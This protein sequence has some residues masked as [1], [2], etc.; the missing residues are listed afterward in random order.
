MRIRELRNSPHFER[1]A[2]PGTVVYY[3]VRQPYTI[4]H[5]GIKVQSIEF[6]STD[7]DSDNATSFWVITEAGHYH[8]EHTDTVTLHAYETIDRGVI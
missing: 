8:Y 4:T 5:Y 2:G 7:A 1:I 6:R 3:R